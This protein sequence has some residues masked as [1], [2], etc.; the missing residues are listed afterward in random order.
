ML[1]KVLL[2]GA[3]HWLLHA[4]VSARGL[5]YRG[6]KATLKAMAADDPALSAD[7][8]TAAGSGSLT[9]RI[10]A[11]RRAT[12]KALEPVGGAWRQDEVVFFPER[13]KAVQ[14]TDQWR[15]FFDSLM[16]TSEST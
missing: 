16:Q 11:L 6:E 15:R 10:E 13:G 12:E 1:C 5:P 4:Y 2:C 7:M 8:E 9:E 14:A 3:V